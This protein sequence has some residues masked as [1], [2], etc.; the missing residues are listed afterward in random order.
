MSDDI[1][2]TIQNLTIQYNSLLLQYQ[3]TYD[4][5]VNYLKTT[6]K[7]ANGSSQ[8]TSSPQVKNYQQQL[9][10]IND[11]LIDVNNQ[12]IILVND[13]DE[14]YKT[15]LKDTIQTNKVL[16]KNYDSLL[17]ERRYIDNYIN[18]QATLQQEVD[19]TDIYTT[20]SY[21]RY[22]LLL[23]ITIILFFLLFKYLIIGNQQS[24]GGVENIKS[25]VIFLLSIMIVFLG[26]ANIFK[27]LNLLIFLTIMI[28]LY[29]FIKIK[30]HEA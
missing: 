4:E 18:D 14:I 8:L 26:L 19:N 16:G 3:K 5:Y 13:N 15:D 25:D 17:E 6:V 11:K 22:I 1:N 9:Q 2:V 21:S 30:K 20:E 23:G 12:I 10:S 27:N 24:G 7:S 29:I 28:I